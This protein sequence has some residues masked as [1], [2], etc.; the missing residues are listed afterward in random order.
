MSLKLPLSARDGQPRRSKDF[1][2]RSS[3]T[4]SEHKKSGKSAR[5]NRGDTTTRDEDLDIVYEAGENSQSQ[6]SVRNILGFMERYDRV[7]VQELLSQLNCHWLLSLDDFKLPVEH[8]YGMITQMTPIN[9]DHMIL[10]LPFDSSIPDLDY[11]EVHQILRELTI[12][13][14]VLNQHPSLQLEVNFDESTTCQ[15]PPAYI[16]TKIGQIMISTDYWLKALWHG[17]N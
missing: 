1:T 13:I 6:P 5:K 12:G 4:S 8:P 14:Y 16:D 3:D 11:R 10:L 7:E 2:S 17:K 15:I 9:E